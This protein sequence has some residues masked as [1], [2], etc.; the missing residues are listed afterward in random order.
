MPPKQTQPQP[1]PAP[2]APLPANVPAT[3]TITPAS[4][5]PQTTA[6]VY[7]A[8]E[9]STPVAQPTPYLTKSSSDLFNERRGLFGPGISG[10]SALFSIIG[11]VGTLLFTIVIIFFSRLL[12]IGPTLSGAWIIVIL[13]VSI[14][15]SASGMV[16]GYIN[17]RSEDT[18]SALGLLGLIVSSSML[19]LMLLIGSYSLKL[20]I[21]YK[22][23]Y[24]SYK[25]SQHIDY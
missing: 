22:K 9:S 11:G 19:I 20:H 12:T 14:S 16:F 5:Q 18:R 15:L 1:N 6:M 2:P 24:D 23:S 7:P 25:D 3:N 10:K 13:L 4:I 17:Q 21:E 8:A